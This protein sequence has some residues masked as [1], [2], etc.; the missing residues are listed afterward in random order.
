MVQPDQIYLNYPGRSKFNPDQKLPKY[1][2][3]PGTKLS[4]SKIP[5]IFSPGIKLAKFN[6][7]RIFRDST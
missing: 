2:V 7:D 3:R 5:E 6:T 4:R 1:L